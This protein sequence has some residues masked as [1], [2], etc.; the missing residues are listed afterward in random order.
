MFGDFWTRQ[1]MTGG[2]V[3]VIAYTIL[4]A[5]AALFIAVAVVE[6]KE[7]SLQQGRD[8]DQTYYSPQ[9]VS[10]DVDKLVEWKITGP[11][12][13]EQFHKDVE[14]GTYADR[15]AIE[16]WLYPDGRHICSRLV[17]YSSPAYCLTPDSMLP[18][19]NAFTDERARSFYDLRGRRGC[20]LITTGVGALLV[21][22]FAV[23]TCTTIGT[24]TPTGYGRAIVTT[25]YHGLNLRP[26]QIGCDQIVPFLVH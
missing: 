19:E 25:R 1:R 24:G 12:S 7:A 14:T 9:V 8:G 23:G 5:F 11:T 16:A 10:R 4:G 22:D 20:F 3:K 26:G 18:V 15:Y 21:E 6:M 2:N 13:Y 17:T